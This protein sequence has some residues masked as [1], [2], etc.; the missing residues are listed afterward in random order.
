MQLS[1]AECGQVCENI[2]SFD[3]SAYGVGVFGMFGG[4]EERVS[5]SCK[6]YLAGAVIDRF[7][8]DVMLIP[9][10]DRFIFTTVVRVSPQFFGWVCGFGADIKITAPQSVVNEFNEMITSV[11][12][13]YNEKTSN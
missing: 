11:L 1:I 13:E 10:G 12:R 7:G 8:K 6:N 2:D 4:R 5:F 9:D 3:P